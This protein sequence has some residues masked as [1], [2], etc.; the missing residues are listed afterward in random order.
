MKD[1]IVDW[2]RKVILD[3]SHSTMQ[4]RHKLVEHGLTKC[5]ANALIKKTRND[6]SKEYNRV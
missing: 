6:I 2:V 1:M 4:M 5:Q 3:R